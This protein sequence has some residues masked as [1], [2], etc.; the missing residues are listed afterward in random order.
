MEKSRISLDIDLSADGKQS[1]Y[2]RLP[3]SVHRSAYGWLPMPIVCVKNGPGKSV[4]L[5][6]GTH[7]DEYE[8]Q[9]ALCRI[10]QEIQ[11]EQIQGRVIILPMAN[12]PAARAGKR[13]SPIDDGN[14]ARIYPGNPAGTATQMIAHFIETEL[15]PHV[16]LVLDLHSGGSSL[17]YLPSS[18]S[19]VETGKPADAE[20]RRY[21]EL[22][23]APYGLDFEGRRGTGSAS[24][25]TAR[26][27]ILRVGCEMGGNGWLSKEYRELCELG[28]KRILAH[29]GI[30]DGTGLPS[31]GKV[32]FLT[33]DKSCFVYAP[34]DGVFEP[35]AKLGATV[36]RGDLAGLIYTPHRPMMAPEPV[37]FDAD[38]LVVCERPDAMCET[39]DC[40]FHLAH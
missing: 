23:G 33:V 34:M 2:A 14:L 25:A 30:L 21:M 35:H 13:V 37:H 5:M 32:N 12:Y 22:F 17:N 18:T 31:P 20:S 28:S 15:M 1:G 40:L 19:L 8:G 6:A 29:L 27:N 10:A 16:D 26:N 9:I 4:L 7:G 39:G 24:D 11:H 36:R 38:G 3:F